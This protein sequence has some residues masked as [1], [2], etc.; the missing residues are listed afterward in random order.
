MKKRTVLLTH[1]LIKQDNC[2]SACKYCYHKPDS[3]S[4][5]YYTYEGELK[6]NLK[7]IIK[8]ANENFYSPIVKISG[9]EIFLMTNLKEF[10]NELFQY[11]PYVLIQ[12]N[13]RHLHKNNN[14]EWIIESKRILLQISLDG[15]DLDMNEYR[16]NDQNILDNLKHSIKVLKENSVYLEITT[17]LNNKNSGRYDEFMKFL[18]ELPAGKEKNTL[19]ST[20]I[21]I[22]DKEGIYTPSETDIEIVDRVVKDYQQYKE[23]LPPEK[24]MQNLSKLMNKEQ[25][26]YQCFN[27]IVSL[28]ITDDGKIKGCTNILPENVLNVGNVLEEDY[29]TLNKRF[30]HTKFQNLLVSTMQRV[31]L[32]KNCFNFCSIYNLYLNDSITLDELCENNYMF[33]LKEVR[34][35]LV[36]LKEDIQEEHLEGRWK[37]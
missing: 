21:L 35:T 24:Y 33:H 17:V 18:C 8:Y 31:P 14:L 16:F 23:V 11:Y 3:K 29:E 2:D 30:G 13:G 12:T 4:E 15:H 32:C 25:L 22:V 36:E 9:G 5:T 19:K 27:P 26:K 37:D 20:P 28:N 7:A 10:V 1:L 34:E 6:K